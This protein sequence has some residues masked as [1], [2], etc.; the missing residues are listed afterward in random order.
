MKAFF[1][2][3]SLVLSALSEGPIEI[4]EFKYFQIAHFSFKPIF[5][6]ELRCLSGESEAA[7]NAVLIFYLLS[8]AGE[9]KRCST[10]ASD[11]QTTIDE[12]YWSPTLR[13]LFV[14]FSH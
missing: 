11:K 8:L 5:D 1:D 9:A 10:D 3:F 4:R 13:T 7:I 12:F 2:D 14:P 6:L